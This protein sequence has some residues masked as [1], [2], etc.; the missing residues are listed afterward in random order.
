MKKIY[1]IHDIKSDGY[2]IPFFIDTEE[3]A[4]RE[5]RTL[6]QREGTGVNLYPEDYEL[7]YLGDYDPLRS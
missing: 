5:F 2:G 4:V 3:M 1:A 7:V 6:V